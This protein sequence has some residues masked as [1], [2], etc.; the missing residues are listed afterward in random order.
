MKEGFPSSN[1]RLSCSSDVVEGL[2]D[3]D[4]T[5]TLPVTSLPDDLPLC[6]RGLELAHSMPCLIV[7]GD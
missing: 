6:G 2:P 7:K 1:L 3:L 5:C 4:T